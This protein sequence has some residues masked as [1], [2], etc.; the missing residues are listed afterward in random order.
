LTPYSVPP[1]FRAHT[2]GPIV[3]RVSMTTVEGRAVLYSVVR[4]ANCGRRIMDVPGDPEIRTRIVGENNASGI[5][6]VV[7]CIKCR[8][9]TE[10][11]EC[12]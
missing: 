8:A 2:S 11:I 12:E 7:P 5:G 6:R 9:Y 10:V 3:A 4:C 1:M